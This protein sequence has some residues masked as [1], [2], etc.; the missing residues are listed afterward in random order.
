MKSKLQ[1]LYALQLIDTSLDELQQQKGDLPAEVQKLEKELADQR[2]HHDAVEQAMRQ[3]FTQRDNADSEIVGL[4]QRLE[5]YKSQQFAVRSNREYDALTREMDA[6]SEA[7]TR[8][9]KEMEQLE[10]QAANARTE[11][12]EIDLRLEAA[13]AHLEE[14]RVA[15]AEISKLT[16]D[17]ELQ[18]QH[19]RQKAVARI[20]K[21]D[22]A[23]Y[24][25]IR[26]AKKGMAV[27]PVKKGACGGCHNRVPPQKLLEL[28][29][30]ERMYTCER[31]GRII[32]SDEIV[33]L[34]AKPG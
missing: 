6:A 7:I 17:E 20:S 3:A 29:Q 24:E 2:Q 25:R 30:N 10:T 4:R 1:Y 33:E 31:C 34:A 5:K 15:L 32:V 9:E 8:L 27:V 22:L 28:R 14:K 12:A 13:K 16:E 18:F 19:E 23:A 26:K 21:P 11:L